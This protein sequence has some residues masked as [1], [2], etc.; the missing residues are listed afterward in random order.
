MHELR[1]RQS[2]EHG[3][4]RARTDAVD[5]E[6]LTESFALAV[7]AE[8]VQQMRILAHDQMREKHHALAKTR[9]VVERAHR[10]V[11]FIRHALHIEEDL[12]WILFDQRARESADHGALSALAGQASNQGGQTGNANDRFCTIAIIARV[13]AR[14]ARPMLAQNARRRRA[15]NPT[16]AFL[17]RA[18]PRSADAG[19]AP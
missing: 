18:A 7:G 6:Q 12:R 2:G 19:P 16:P 5:L 9:K 10:H 3:Q 1:D 8:A 14:D 15:R 4:R 11:Y 17:A 13:M